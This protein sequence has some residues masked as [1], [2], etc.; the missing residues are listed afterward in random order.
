MRRFRFRLERVLR[1]RRQHLREE[2][3]QLAAA[4]RALLAAEAALQRAEAT[5]A[6]LLARLAARVTGPSTAS[7]AEP[8]PELAALVRWLDETGRR[9]DHWAIER[10]RA[11][12][13][14]AAR[15]EQ[16][17]KAHRDVR[18]LELLRE[19]RRL[20]HARAAER[21]ERIALDE[22][23]AIRYVQRQGPT[24]TG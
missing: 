10:E 13:A 22:V 6:G 19:R 15:R 16:V 20:A 23:G 11:Q 7:A 1:L 3:V 2:R 24:P 14:Q 21:E 18:V 8:Q 4:S 12:Q 9:R 5:R 17:I